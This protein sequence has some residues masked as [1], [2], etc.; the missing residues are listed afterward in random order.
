M[1]LLSSIWTFNS[2]EVI[3]ILTEGGP[4]SATTTLIVDTYKT[5]IANF[6][7]GK[8]AARAVIIVI[9]LTLWS[10]VYLFILNKLNKRFGNA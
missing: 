1:M 9:V 8:G 10:I 7:F 3:W 2:F 5:A 4:R 6:K